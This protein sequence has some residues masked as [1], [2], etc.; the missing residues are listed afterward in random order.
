MRLTQKISHLL[1]LQTEEKP[2]FMWSLLHAFSLGISF[3]IL[4]NIPMAIFLTKFGGE[5]LPYAFIATAAIGLC[6]GGVYGRI[7]R[8][9]KFSSLQI[10]VL[11]STNVLIFL[12]WICISS[13]NSKWMVAGSFIL[14]RILFDYIQ[15]E[16]WSVLNRIFNLQQAKRF[17]GIFGGASSIS[18]I[19][20]GFSTPFLI[21]WMGTNQLL[22]LGVLAGSISLVA[23]IKIKHYTSEKIDV[24]VKETGDESNTSNAL[25]LTTLLKK[26]YFRFICLAA[27]ISN[28]SCITLYML[29][30]T[31]AQQQFT[32]TA[33]LAIFFSIFY[34]LADI[35]KLICNT[36][37]LKYFL[38]RFGI[39]VTLVIQPI[40]DLIIGI[41]AL[42]THLIPPVA[43]YTFW[44]IALMQIFTSFYNGG[45][46]TPAFL[47][48]YQPLAAKERSVI[49]SKVELII[50]PLSCC[51][52]SVVILVASKT[53][54]ITL[55]PGIILLTA[56][57]F[58]GVGFTLL[59]K[60]DYL[61]A[62]RSALT[63]ASF[64]QPQFNLADKNTL[65]LLQQKLSSPF[66]E[67][68]IFC[69]R[70][71]ESINPKDYEKVLTFCVDA[72]DPIIR[73][74]VI[75]QLEK[76][77]NLALFEKIRF[78]AKNDPSRLVRSAAYQALSLST[79]K[80][81]ISL[82][83]SCL[84]DPD[85]TIRSGALLGVFLHL[86]AYYKQASEELF[87]MLKHDKAE[88]RQCAASIIGKS[89]RHDLGDLLIALLEDTDLSVRRAAL[90]AAG[91]LG[92]HNV[93]YAAIQSDNTALIPQSVIEALVMD[94]T[95]ITN[96][97][98]DSLSPD[99]QQVIIKACGYLQDPESV[100][101]LLNH[102]GSKNNI[103]FHQVA[104][105]LMHRHYQSV[106]SSVLMIEELIDKQVELINRCKNHMTMIP[107]N[108]AT[109]VLYGLFKR[110][111]WLQQ[112]SLLAL[113]SFI[114]KHKDMFA[115]HTALENVKD[116]QSAY[117]FE[118][119]SEHLLPKHKDL[120]IN[121]L[122]PLLI[123]TSTD[124]RLFDN[125]L[126]DILNPNLSLYNHC[127]NAAALY[128][129]GNQGKVAF[130]ETLKP[131]ISDPNKLIAETATWA[132]GKLGSL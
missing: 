55:L 119:L 20:T 46:R 84:N 110:F 38:T 47:V 67:E 60:S 7:E 58:L 131:F 78:S 118:L 130:K 81:D 104:V 98:W 93:L 66:P 70:T 105:V 30:S 57:N 36:L 43:V 28:F 121:S 29:F 115:I 35:L 54:G 19:C 129:V 124:E 101:F 23:L 96:V 107:I 39:F 109:D 113:L 99:S 12:V 95:C 122:E 16:F 108:T 1:R 92:N 125:L 5:G 94:P 69:L 62:L 114:Y 79:E 132:M 3:V 48:L 65:L 26:K 41:A 27:A 111:L 31:L 82:V 127:I 61:N 77:P 89:A 51:L 103:N 25:N 6:L 68:I 34:A 50:N 106:E 86:P 88:Q 120:V 52:I 18:G 45:I 71:L 49:Q 74:H 76:Y 64:I 15:L 44:V 37:V 32:D 87:I 24:I 73:R 63:K 97:Q 112:E 80:K 22:L 21:P 56:L 83:L 33:S 4:L 100:S 11:V 72:P 90:L 102:L 75:L 59:L 91:K 42:I 53:F 8:K 10:G 117:A 128:Y 40:L 14:C 9:I 126:S 2:I 123:E 116:D 85:L 17:F 13:S